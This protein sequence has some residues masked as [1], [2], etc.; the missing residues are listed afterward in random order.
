MEGYRLKYLTKEWY[1]LCQRTGL[2]FGMKVHYG[3]AVYNEELYLRLYKRKEKEYVKMQNEV[4]DVNPRFMLELDGST[5]VKLDRFV[6][7]EEINE[8]DTIVY[9]MPLDERERIQKSIEEYDTRPPFN[10]KKCAE[11]FQITQETIMRAVDNKLPHELAGQIADM[12]VFSLGYCTKE[13]LKQLKRLCKENEKKVNHVSKEY[14]KAQQKENIPQIIRE[15]FGFH[16]CQ[17]TEFT[18]GKNIVMCLDT[19]GG[20]TNFYKITFIAP[21]IIKQ[22][23]HIV[24][25]FWLY[26]EI[27]HTENGYEAHMLFEGEYLTELIIKC[28]DIIIE[29]E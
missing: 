17:V 6:N 19:R 15:R 3:A 14:S 12:R 20:F 28:N 10:E 25:S 21:D 22:E 29:E 2:H 7:S 26:N 27:Y 1:E 18:V 13:V 4:Y 23:E 11:E 16:D 9:H 8:E 24:G 5:F